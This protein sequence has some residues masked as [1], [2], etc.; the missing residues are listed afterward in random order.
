MPD[1][2]EVATLTSK[3]QLTLPKAIRQALGVDIGGKIAFDLRDNGE[4]IVSRADADHTDPAIGAFLAL[5]ETDIGKGRHLQSLPD[6]LARAVRAAADHT[7]EPMMD[8]DGDIA[9]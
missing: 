9:L 4:V 5:L 6:D 7:E 1:I 2:H 3:G 8:I